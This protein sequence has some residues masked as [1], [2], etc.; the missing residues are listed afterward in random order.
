M[1]RYAKRWRDFHSAFFGLRSEE[2]ESGNPRAIWL[3]AHYS[4]EERP[5]ILQEKAKPEPGPFCML[6]SPEGGLWM[7]SGFVSESFRERFRTL[8]AR[9]GITLGSLKGIDA[10][11]FWLHRLHLDLVENGSKLIVGDTSQR[12]NT[13]LCVCEASSTF[14]SQLEMKALAS[15]GCGTSVA[16][17]RQS[18]TQ[19]KSEIG[20]GSS[21]KSGDKTAEGA[22]GKPGGRPRMDAERELVRKLKGE[23]NTWKEIT[24]K[25]NKQFGHSKGPEAYRG[26]LKS[27][28]RSRKHPGINGQN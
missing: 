28:S 19:S 23:G 6:K 4:Q 2:L 13:I 21:V 5:E 16:P 15:S 20:A 9:A 14:C 22:E 10:E 8:A 25:V 7:Y 1:S 17:A 18:P 3:C 27:H 11:V 24:A 26:L 12:I